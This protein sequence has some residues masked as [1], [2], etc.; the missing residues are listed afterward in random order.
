VRALAPRAMLGQQVGSKSLAS[1]VNWN[2]TEAK[3][4]AKQKFGPYLDFGERRGRH[5]TLMRTIEARDLLPT[6]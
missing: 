5:A 1:I 6:C 2:G 3:S 4:G